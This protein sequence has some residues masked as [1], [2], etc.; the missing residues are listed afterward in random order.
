MA[1]LSSPVPVQHAFVGNVR[2]V[3]KGCQIVGRGDIVIAGEFIEGGASPELW[4]HDGF[5]WGRRERFVAAVQ[6][7]STLTEFG[8]EHGCS[9]SL[10]IRKE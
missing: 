1:I 5:T 8:F 6:Q 9:L 4:A 3:L 2:G 10:R 7:A